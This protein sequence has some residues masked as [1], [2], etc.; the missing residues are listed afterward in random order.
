MPTQLYSKI[1]NNPLSRNPAGV[2]AV[3]TAAGLRSAEDYERTF[4][5]KLTENEYFFNPQI[6]F[7]IFKYSTTTR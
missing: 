4:A 5:R 3:L 1:I 2:S 7:L 6:G